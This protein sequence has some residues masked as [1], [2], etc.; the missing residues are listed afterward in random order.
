MSR[1]IDALVSEHELGHSDTILAMCKVVRAASVVGQ[2]YL[3][4]PQNP[5][6]NPTIRWRHLNLLIEALR[7]FER[8]GR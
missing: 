7:Q 6:N 2:E 5:H 8:E 4:C 3:K 1:K